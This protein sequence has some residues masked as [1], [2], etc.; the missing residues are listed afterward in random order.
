MVIRTQP[1]RAS[2][3]NFSESKTLK[4]TCALTG[5]GDG[6]VEVRL[7]DDMNGY[8]AADTLGSVR[9]ILPWLQE[10]IAHF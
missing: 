5:S 9:E 10:A 7:G 2:H 3:S 6:V 8:V 1:R 4:S